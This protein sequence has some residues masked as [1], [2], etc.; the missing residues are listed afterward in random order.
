M[1]IGRGV[2][3]R[4][5]DEVNHREEEDPSG[6]IRATHVELGHALLELVGHLLRHGGHVCRVQ[7][8][9]I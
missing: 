1:S 3:T 9:S 4:I 6:R 2:D 7:F 5:L 8:V